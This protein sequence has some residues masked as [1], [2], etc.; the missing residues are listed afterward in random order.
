LKISGAPHRRVMC[1]IS[2]WN[3][4]GTLSS[5]VGDANDAVVLGGRRTRR[6]VQTALLRTTSNHAI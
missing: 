4:N 3:K 1:T 5:T 2:R 6:D